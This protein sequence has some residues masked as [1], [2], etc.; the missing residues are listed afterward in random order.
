MYKYQTKEKSCIILHQQQA[1]INDNLYKSSRSVIYNYDES[2]SDFFCKKLAKK[3]KTHIMSD[4]IKKHTY[5][6]AS[7][8]YKAA[9]NSHSSVGNIYN[10]NKL[11]LW[12]NLNKFDK[13]MCILRFAPVNEFI[14]FTLR[15][16][17]EYMRN[18]YKSSKTLTN[19]ISESIRNKYK[20]VFNCNPQWS[21]VI[22]F[23]KTCK[24]KDNLHPFHI[25]GIIQFNAQKL[26]ILK[27]ILKEVAFDRNYKHHPMNKNIVR[28]GNIIA[29]TGWFE[30]LTKT[31]NEA[32][33]LLFISQNLVQRVKNFYLKCLK[34]TL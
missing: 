24:I 33:N 29:P 2:S 32:L 19:Y 31:Q 12:R 16:S 3:P 27:K 28:F 22:E 11:P 13:L 8:I 4:D 5:Q 30:Y 34:K 6:L 23:D 26:N 15:F 17:T 10:Y 9:Y 14:A 18:A 1:L 25:H 7:N 20:N 21:F